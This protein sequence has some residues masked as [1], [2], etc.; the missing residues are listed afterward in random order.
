MKY[1]KT[2]DIYFSLCKSI[3]SFVC[4]AIS[5]T[6]ES[7]IKYWTGKWRKN[8]EVNQYILKP[9]KYTTIFLLCVFQ[10]ISSHLEN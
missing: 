10:E 2:V 3:C 7:P 4:I 9:G 1:L 5:E 8:S 6:T